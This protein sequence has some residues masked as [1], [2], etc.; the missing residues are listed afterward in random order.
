MPRTDL[1]MKTFGTQISLMNVI[2][3]GS[4]LASFSLNCKMEKQHINLPWHKMHCAK[5]L[6]IES[7]RKKRKAYVWKTYYFNGIYRSDV[8]W[9][10]S[11]PHSKLC[12]P[13]PRTLLIL[14]FWEFCIIL[15]VTL[16]YVEKCFFFDPASSHFIPDYMLTI[17]ETFFHYVRCV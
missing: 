2:S 14:T 13:G 8:V 11:Q 4:Q 1:Y 12:W 9:N 15:P 17:R 10:Y 7:V 6:D 5:I 3:M 16:L